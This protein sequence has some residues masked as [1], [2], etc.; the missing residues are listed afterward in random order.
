MSHNDIS[1]HYVEGRFE[2]V[3]YSNHKQLEYRMMIAIPSEPPPAEGYPIIYA[4]DGDAVFATF[5]EA[6]RLQTRKPHGYDPVVIV[7]IGYPSREPFEMNR[8]CY[9]FTM[10]A[11]VEN[12]PARPNG[13]EW[14][15]HGGADAFLQFIEAEL[16]PAIEKEYPIDTKR[17][18]IFGHSLGGL[19]V[20]HALF[21]RPQ[22]FQNYAAGSPSIWWNHHAVLEEAE[23]F[24]KLSIKADSMPRLMLTIGA[25]ELPNMVKDAEQL[26][27]RLLPLA[28]KGFKSEIVKFS[29]ESHVSVLPAAISRVLRFALSSKHKE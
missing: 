14:P 7:G 2:Q 9:D 16:R 26:A 21:T 5:A 15:E 27:E 28:E 20:L 1:N 25:D 17:Q 3:I 10:P 12:L 19:L 13:Q 11:Q 6:A 8:R 22:A 24:G 29:G 23:G 18:S 4:L